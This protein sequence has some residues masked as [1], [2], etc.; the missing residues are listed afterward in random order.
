MKNVLLS[1]FIASL[2]S[3]CG[4]SNFSASLQNAENPSSPKSATPNSPAPAPQGSVA[5][6][7]P[8]DANQRSQVGA[9]PIIKAESSLTSSSAPIS[10]YGALV[11]KSSNSLQPVP[12][13]SVTASSGKI[14]SI[15]LSDGIAFALSDK[16]DDEATFVQFGC[17]AKDAQF[18]TLAK[19]LTEM[20]LSAGT[21][22]EN[23]E[24][25]ARLFF[26]CGKGKFPKAYISV[27]ADRV[28]LINSEYETANYGGVGFL[29]IVANKMT[30]IGKNVVISKGA[31]SAGVLTDTP[32]LLFSVSTSLDGTGTL[33]LKTNPGKKLVGG[34]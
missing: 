12:Q 27:Q 3:A 32:A 2:L 4:G 18:V 15:G 30:L 9:N 11:T 23:L 24:I 1:I 10:L 13:I 7:N 21:F 25:K 22:S 20:K 31:D 29:A 5:P 16:I 33:E 6:S 34:I 28:V 17:T 14:T 8:S 19:G 26:V